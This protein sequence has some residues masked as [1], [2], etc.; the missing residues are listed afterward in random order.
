M[1]LN[2]LLPSSRLAPPLGSSGGLDDDAL[3]LCFVTHVLL[4]AIA[5]ASHVSF[6]IPPDASSAMP[7]EGAQALAFFVPVKIASGVPLASAAPYAFPSSDASASRGSDCRGLLR[8]VAAPMR[9]AA[10]SNPADRWPMAVV[11]AVLLAAVEDVLRH[12]ESM[13]GLLAA[14]PAFV[15]VVQLGAIANMYTVQLRYRC[16][17]LMSEMQLDG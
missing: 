2:P 12:R 6:A 17:V 5:S 1:L 10:A 4:R 15:S 14:S 11:A 8:G 3:A 7:M 16:A 13:L 9:R